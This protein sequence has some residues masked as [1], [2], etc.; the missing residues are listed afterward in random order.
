VSRRLII[1]SIIVA[2]AAASG[3]RGKP[4]RREAPSNPQG[5]GGTGSGLAA[6]I[7]SGSDKVLH[8]PA[9]DG[10]APKPTKGPLSSATIEKLRGLVFDGFGKE[11]R[12]KDTSVVIL[13]R[14]EDR[15]KLKATVQIKPCEGACMPIELAKWQ[16]RTDLNDQMAKELRESKDTKFEVGSTDLNAM[17]M[18]YTYQ[19]GMVSS[20]AGMRYTDAYTLWFNDGQNEIRVIADYIDNQPDSV[21]AMVDMAPKDSLEKLAKAFMDVYTQA[22]AN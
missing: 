18:I 13:F 3:C 17:P 11:N 5:S 2:V 9:G 14:T 21:A 6:A 7:G 22:W 15:P 16:A 1:S 19:V 4:E 8:L 10:T 20:Q 12:G